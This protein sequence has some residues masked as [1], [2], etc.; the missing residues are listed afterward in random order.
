M[1]L[2]TKLLALSLPIAFLSAAACKSSHEQAGRAALEVPETGPDPL[3]RESEP[4][5]APS[6]AAS[7]Q[8]GREPWQEIG[9]SMR[10]PRGSVEGIGCDAVLPPGWRVEGGLGGLGITESGGRATLRCALVD[11]NDRA[12]LRVFEY[13]CDGAWLTPAELRTRRDGFVQQADDTRDVSHAGLIAWAGTVKGTGQAHL[14]DDKSP[15]ELV[16]SFVGK[17][18]P[19]DDFVRE[20]YDRFRAALGK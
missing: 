20:A 16:I 19:T 17:P 14:Y 9:I 8:A 6:A 1:R 7:S 11:P 13:N 2:E 12:H 4:S 10:A 3:P 18:P 15:C 5:P